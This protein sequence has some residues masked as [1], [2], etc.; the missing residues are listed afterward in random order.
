MPRTARELGVGDPFDPFANLDGAARYLARQL[1]TFGKPH[2][3][4]AAYNAGPSRVAK[5]RGVPVLRETRLYVANV[6]NYWAELQASSELSATE[7][8]R[9]L[10]FLR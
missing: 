8:A 3:A 9:S 5:A 10:G 2:L 7:M 6:L 4:L 1:I